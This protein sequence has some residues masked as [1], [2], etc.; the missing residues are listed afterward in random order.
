MGLMF[1]KNGQ[2]SSRKK[3]ATAYTLELLESRVLLSA[4]LAG[5]AQAMTVKPVEVP[6]QA[7][8]LN[9]P[10]AHAHVQE[11]LSISQILAQPAPSSL[12]SKLSKGEWCHARV[13]S[14]S[15]PSWNASSVPNDQPLTVPQILA[16]PQAASQ[17]SNVQSSQNTE[18]IAPPVQSPPSSHVSAGSASSEDLT[19]SAPRTPSTSQTESQPMAQTAVTTVQNDVSSPNPA[20]QMLTVSQ[21]LAQPTQPVSQ[22]SNVQSSVVTQL[23]A[24]PVQNETTSPMSNTQASSVSD[25]APQPAP[26]TPQVTQEQS[27]PVAQPVVTTPSTPTAP[28]TGLTNSGT[29]TSDA[30]NPALPQA[31]VDTAMPNTS[32]TVRVGPHGDYTGLQDALN[33]VPLGTTILLQP[34][35]SYTTTNDSGFILPNKTTGTG[36][37][38]IRPDVPDSALPAPDTRLTPAD[39]AMMPK[40]VRGNE[41]SYAMSVEPGAHN[42][43]IIGVEFMSQGNADT[44]LNGAFINLDGMESSLS[45]QSNHI[46]LDRI[47][48]HGPSAPG[49]A[50]VKFGVILGGQYQ[51]VIDSTIE[52]LVSDDG[53]AKAIAG[54]GGAGPWLITNNLL[55]ASGE[56][57]MIGGATPII[58]GLTPSD[59]EIS[60]NHFYKPL[61]WRDDPAYTSG[62]N[63]VVTK[64]LLELKNAQRVV[65]DANVFENV[66]PDGQSGYAVVLTPRGG[67][68]TGSDPWTIV[69]DVTIANNQFLN[70]ANGFAISG[71][72]PTISLDQGGPT[73]Q[74][75]RILIDNNVFTGLGGDYNPVNLSGNFATIGMGPSDLQIKHNTVASYAGTNI[76]GTTLVFTYGISDEGALFPLI[77]FVLQDNHFAA[78]EYP[79]TLGSAPDLNTLMPGYIWTNNVVA[80]PWPTSGGW[81]AAMMPQGNGN[82]YPS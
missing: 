66:W 21:M 1:S 22:P 18:P 57:I 44:R 36:W 55:S 20:G 9:V 65:I 60:H 40:I 50:G 4:D 42:Y 10:A 38:V 68:A 69:S 39:S 47:Y 61:E 45:A 81:T 73:Q 16:Q 56:N 51:A 30:I 52:S 34:G 11:N 49:S 28:S 12:L 27:Q 8:V 14:Q 82:T 54:W 63:P 23:E 31:H 15:I 43:S 19:Q 24:F 75:G 76:R 5:A 72:G 32:L 3:R 2:K 58:S 41:N 37:I 7:V 74:G 53:E 70:V 71:G 35:V 64:N 48:I 26:P 67:G 17:P 79:M 46:I 13:G 78:R 62:P 25:T 77:N 29:I 80:G 33:N 59:I 6:Q